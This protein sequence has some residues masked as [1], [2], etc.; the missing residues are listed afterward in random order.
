MRKLEESSQ[1]VKDRM[2]LE[3]ILSAHPEHCML[4][5]Y[6]EGIVEVIGKHIARLRIRVTGD[7]P[8]FVM[9]YG[10]PEYPVKKPT[11]GEVDDGTVLFCI[12][13]E[14]LDSKNG[15]DLIVRLLFPAASP[16]VFFDEHAER[17][18]I[19][20]RLGIQSAYQDMIEEAKEG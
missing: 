4:P 17:L 5:P 12:L 20:F 19:E 7:V 2:A 10:E 8:D 6:P 11:V 16:Q 18:Y 9:E 14:F 3:V 1:E 13:H 15:C